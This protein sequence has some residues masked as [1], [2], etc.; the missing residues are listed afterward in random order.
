MEQRS[1]GARNW[2]I[3]V[4]LLIVAG[5]AAYFVGAA[6]EHAARARDAA[7]AKA[8]LQSAQTQVASLQ[9]V[10]QLLTADVWAYR[11]AAALDNRNFGVANDA[12]TRVVASLNSV[13]VAAAGLESEPLNAL[14]GEASG[15]KISV[16]TNLEAQR[17]QLLRLATDTTALV[18][19]SAAKTG[20]PD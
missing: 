6:V 8:Q 14:K 20:S 17:A 13:N 7:A 3:V 11:A 2:L 1:S 10:K 18:E 19:K 16:A 12:V 15:V 5:V 9:S 4:G